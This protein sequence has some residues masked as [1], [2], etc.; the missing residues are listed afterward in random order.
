MR[1]P[2]LPITWRLPG[3]YKVVFRYVED[4]HDGLRGEWCGFGSDKV[5]NV[6]VK[7]EPLDEMAD[8]VFHEMVHA[9]IDWHAAYLRPIQRTFVKTLLEEAA[10]QAKETE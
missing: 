1:L 6:Y 2:K 9:L 4:L 3:G 7:L 5:G 10:L 8:T